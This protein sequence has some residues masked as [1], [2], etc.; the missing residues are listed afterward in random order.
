M[1]VNRHPDPAQDAPPDR[2]LWPV[3]WQRAYGSALMDE[4]R[5]AL[6]LGPDRTLRASVIDD[7]CTYYDCDETQCVDE[8]VNWG[9]YFNEEWD[10]AGRPEAFHRTTRSSSFS[11]LWA[12]YCQAE[13][14][15]WPGSFAMVDG[16]QRAGV[17]GGDHLDF[18]SG[19]GVTSQ[20]FGRLGYRTTLAD[21]STSM[22]DFARFRLDRRGTP[23]TF[24]DLNKTSLPVAAFDVITAIDVLSLVADPAA[25]LQALH[26]ALKPD[27]V[28]HA[29]ISARASKEA[30]WQLSRD[31]LPLRRVLQAAGFEPLTLTRPNV[32]RRVSTAGPVH[33]YRAA[34]DA[35]L[36]GPVR[37]L[38]RNARSA[39]ITRTVG[40]HMPHLR[41]HRS[42]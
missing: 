19:V 21:I 14:Y 3:Y 20:L 22:L 1:T 24:I 6:R 42:H 29:T 11:L 25:T 12:A 32:Y 30:R 7:L 18:G 23:A 5:A 13:G 4:F 36:L 35:L 39:P 10:A 15:T 31:D 26:A 38:Y 17:R 28:L 2:S 34:R 27:G 37:Q 8:C 40:Q 9:R 33:A 41:P 16:V